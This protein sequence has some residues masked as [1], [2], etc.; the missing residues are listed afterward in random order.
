[1]AIKCTISNEKFGGL[2]IVSV[3]SQKIENNKLNLLTLLEMN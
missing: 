1:M 2:Y 3:H